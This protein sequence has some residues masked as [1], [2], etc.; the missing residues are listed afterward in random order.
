M[1][2][3]NPLWAIASCILIQTAG[4][5]EHDHGGIVRARR[6]VKELALVFTGHEFADGGGVIAAALRRHNVKA[7]FFFTGDFYRTPEFSPLVHALKKDGHYLGAHSDKHLLYVSWENRDSLLV[8]KE[9]FSEDLNTNYAEMRKFGI[10]KNDALYFIPPFEWYNSTVSEWARES[11]LQLLTFTPGVLSHA[12]WTY[13]ALG[14]QYRSSD[15]IVHHLLQFEETAAHGLNGFIVLM[16]VGADPGRT[17]KL[18]RRLDMLLATLKKR[19]YRLERLDR[20]LDKYV[21]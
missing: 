8:N 9:T 2:L 15:T 19:G 14:K 3:Q 16:H 10:G 18:Y 1:T 21:R 4:Q 5:L 20:M 13:P 17:D 12:D 6:D 11:G 7:A